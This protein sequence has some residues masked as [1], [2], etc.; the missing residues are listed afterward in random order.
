[1]AIW[2]RGNALPF[3]AL[4]SLLASIGC[5]RPLLNNRLQVT[6]ASSVTVESF[7]VHLPKSTREL[8]PIAP[9]A[10]RSVSFRPAQADTAGELLFVA[11]WSNARLEGAAGGTLDGSVETYELTLENDA[12]YTVSAFGHTWSD[13]PA[14]PKRGRE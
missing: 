11:K 8:G 14:S 6:N 9:G 10:T 3:I 2:R 1:M 4:L 5:S 12:L 13:G 7:V